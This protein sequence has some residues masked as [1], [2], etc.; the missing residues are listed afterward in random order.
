MITGYAWAENQ[1]DLASQTDALRR[2][3]CWQVVQEVQLSG[4]PRPLLE[5]IL[6]GLRLGDLLAVANPSALGSNAGEFLDALAEIE[7]RHAFLVVLDFGGI[8]L[9]S[10]Q[11]NV[12][13]LVSPILAALAAMTRPP[14]APAE[15]G[16]RLAQDRRSLRKNAVGTDREAAIRAALREGTGVL[17]IAR[18]VGCGVSAVQR[19]ARDLAKEEVAF[20]L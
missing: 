18:R 2:I 12:R 9:D 14:T 1:D 6:R 7:R 4:A 13:R 16:R 20:P 10:R 5:A 3:G 17:T 8:R 19:V 15:Q 11:L